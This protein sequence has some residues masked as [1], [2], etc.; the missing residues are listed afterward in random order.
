MRMP[1]ITRFAKNDRPFSGRRRLAALA[2]TVVLAGGVQLLATDTAWACGAPDDAPVTAPAKPSAPNEQ[3]G[4]V[5]LHGQGATT[6]FLKT[7]ATIGVGGPK[8]EF[9]V[10]IFNGTGADYHR[11]VPGIAFF[12]PHGPTPKASQVTAEVMAHGAWQRVPLRRGCDPAISGS[13]PSAGGPLADGHAVR[14]RFRVGLSA[15]V[16]KDV[17]GLQV[18]ASPSS[19]RG[20]I[21]EVKVVH[22][23]A[24]ATP[25]A[26]AKPK[27]TPTKDAKDAKGTTGT[28][29]TKDTKPAADRTTTAT[30]TAAPT[31]APAAPKAPAATPT[32]APATTAP[33]GTPELA[34]T[35][36]SSTNT[37]LAL[38]SAA[39]LALGAGVLIAVRRL[40]PQR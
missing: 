2:A 6:T 26:P 12:N 35:G 19:G 4:S 33:A 5:E 27:P 7:P 38:T 29:G 30:P 40:R 10:Q 9:E 20:A 34:Q 13:V 14:Y 24:A 25:T 18:I 21:T 15:D 39:F 11:V 23:K 37:F 32:A 17:D 8:V 1:V 31:A 16:A 36:S 28:T 22:P 3:D